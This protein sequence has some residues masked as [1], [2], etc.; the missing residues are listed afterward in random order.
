MSDNT[1]SRYALSFSIALLAVKKVLRCYCRKYDAK[2]LSV[3]G[4]TGR[5]ENAL[6]DVDFLCTCFLSV[7][8]ATNFSELRARAF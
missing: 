7:Q 8:P 4:T 6:R 5:R 1:G 2:L 3:E